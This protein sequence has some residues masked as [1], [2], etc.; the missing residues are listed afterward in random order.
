MRLLSLASFS[1]CVSSEYSRYANL[2]HEVLRSWKVEISIWRGPLMSSKNL[3][4]IK[5]FH[6]LIVS[7]L[8]SRV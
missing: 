8:G 7:L 5:S 6:S 3:N 1:N 2:V 4:F